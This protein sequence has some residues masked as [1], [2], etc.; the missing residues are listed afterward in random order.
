MEGT[1]RGLEAVT[2]HVRDVEKARAFYGNL[3]GLREVQYVPG[4]AVTYSIPGTSTVLL[5]HIKRPEEQGREPGTVSGLVFEVADVAG[6]CDTIR[7]AGGSV[8]DEPEKYTSRAGTYVK[9][10]IADPDGNEFMIRLR[11]SD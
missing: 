9:A 1:L 10:T 2:I 4:G 8:T 6:A 5:M 11:L 3:L 7:A